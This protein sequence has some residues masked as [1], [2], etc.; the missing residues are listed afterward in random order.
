MTETDAKKNAQRP[1]RRLRSRDQAAM[2]GHGRGHAN[3]VARRAGEIR[4][5]RKR[6]PRWPAMP[7]LG[8]RPK[9]SKS[10]VRD[11]GLAHI[12]NLDTIVRGE[13]SEEVLWQWIG[14]AL[15]WSYV[16]SALE[17]RDGPRFRDAAIA[18]RRQLEIATAVTTRYGR[19]GR[20]G[21]T[22]PE[23]QQA[24]D[25]CEWMDA[26]AEVVDQPTA[27]MAADWSD[28]KTNQW[29]MQCRARAQRERKA[30]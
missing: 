10:Q 11:L 12:G 25:A 9:L 23:Y 20:V 6:I 7:P 27:S 3:R 5:S 21:F 28:A 4:M 14:G 30:A 16:A 2:H 29:A 19:T 17:R 18:M 13:A 8:L 22:G 15:T 1:G 26:L 24:K